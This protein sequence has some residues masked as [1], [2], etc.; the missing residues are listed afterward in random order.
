MCKDSLYLLYHHEP[1]DHTA[2]AVFT[3]ESDAQEMCVDLTMEEMYETFLYCLRTN[4]YE[5][6]YRDPSCG[7]TEM[8]LALEEA[9]WCN[10]YFIIKVPFFP[11]TSKWEAKVFDSKE[12]PV[13]ICQN[14]HTQV[15]AGDDRNWCPTCGA[16]M[17]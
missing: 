8:E 4:A 9:S 11:I 17:N 15:W 12:L 5:F 6:C 2:V 14:C 13:Y 16:M 10:N 1:C 3:D 7:L